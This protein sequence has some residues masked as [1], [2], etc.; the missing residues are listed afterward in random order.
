MAVWMQILGIRRM[1]SIK[2][3]RKRLFDILTSL[4]FDF[5]FLDEKYFDQKYDRNKWILKKQG[6]FEYMEYSFIELNE[7][8]GLNMNS[9]RIDFSNPDFINFLGPWHYFVHWGDFVNEGNKK[10]T[11]GWR[12]IF[13]QIAK[14]YGLKELIYSSECAFRVEM[15]YEGEESFENLLKTFN[16]NPELEKSN[17]YGLTPVEHYI[18]KINPV[19]NNV[20]N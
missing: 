18:E 10:S 5:G 20:Y 13:F 4:E 11:E 3:E 8:E 15:V 7:T 17:L 6:Q 19:A 16:E 12:K 14:K 2:D 1:D 9:I